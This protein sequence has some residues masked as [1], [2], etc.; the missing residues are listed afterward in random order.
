MLCSFTSAPFIHTSYSLILFYTPTELIYI[1]M[2]DAHTPRQEH[3]RSLIVTSTPLEKDVEKEEEG[4]SISSPK[5]LTSPRS[6]TPAQSELSPVTM[7]GPTMVAYPQQLHYFPQ[8]PNYMSHQHQTRFYQSSYHP[9]ASSQASSSLPHIPQQSSSSAPSYPEMHSHTNMHGHAQYPQYPSSQLPPTIPFPVNQSQNLP[10]TTVTSQGASFNQSHNQVYYDPYSQ[11]YPPPLATQSFNGYAM[12]YP[13]QPQSLVPTQSSQ[14]SVWPQNQYYV[15][16]TYTNSG[17]NPEPNQ[18]VTH[19]GTSN[20]YPFRCGGVPALRPVQTN[21][22]PADF[23]TSHSGLDNFSSQQRQHYHVTNKGRRLSPAS[24][25]NTGRSSV[26]SSTVLGSSTL[27]ITTSEGQKSKVAAHPTLPRGPPRK[28]RQSGHALWVGNLPPGTNVL[29]L[30][31]YFATS[32]IESV[33]LISKSNCAFVNYR[34]ETACNEAMIRFHDSRFQ[35]VRLVCR[36]R[37]SASPAPNVLPQTSTSEI[38]AG[39]HPIIEDEVSSSPENTITPDTELKQALS[40]T[41]TRDNKERFFILKS[42]TVEDLD[43]SVRNGVWATQSHNESALNDAFHVCYY[44]DFLH[45]SHMY[46]NHVCNRVPKVFFLFFLQI[47]R[48]NTLATRA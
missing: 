26:A 10:T 3:R 12:A 41:I 23:E 18:H 2:G 13:S 46:T 44:L 39:I 28:P 7:Y 27:S 1:F 6:I 9:Y 8:Q 36:L 14:Y 33:F 22:G 20:T 37:R 17:Y 30:K 4:K 42:L 31:D 45:L 19:S 48:E 34:T 11:S 16:V 43:L 40:Q 47:S 29:A 24:S 25:I 35:G 38:V 15:P 32:E 5:S 21:F